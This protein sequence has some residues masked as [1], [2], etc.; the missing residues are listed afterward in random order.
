M[1]STYSAL[2]LQLMTTGENLATWGNVTNVNLGT[3]VEELAAGSAD[4]TFASGTVT[5]TLTDSNAT[6]TA[7]NM[8]LRLTGTSGGAQNLV[9]P[10]IE[11]VYI[12]SN[13]C[14]D[15]I[16]VKNATGTGIAVPA[17]KTLWVYNNAT[18]VV[19]VV[20]HLTT[21]TLGTAL[22]VASGG[23]GVTSLA[24]LTAGSA[25]NIAGGAAGQIPRQTGAGATGFT[26]ATFPTTAGTS[27]NVLT[28]DGTNWASATPTGGVTS[29]TGTA[30]QITVTG[31]TT[32]TLSIP[33]AP[34]F[35]G[36]A[37]VGSAFSTYTA[38]TACTGG[39]AATVEAYPIAQSSV[40]TVQHNT[41][42]EGATAIVTRLWAS[43]APVIVSQGGQNCTF[44]IS[45]ADLKATFTTTGTFS[46]KRLNFR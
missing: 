43:G 32:P 7:R 3:A 36:A 34:V 39:V 15:A 9:V 35:T 41:A 29:V 28:S 44:S 31:T 1:A 11:K 45:G 14:A 5:L 8:R 2:K 23:T 18:N 10:A 12:V 6:Q 25:T 42:D 19:D 22:P 16:T 38:S 40:C 33:A 21:L 46:Y 20:T 17:G 37:T 26:T 13:D 4:V 27:G 24:S 30:N